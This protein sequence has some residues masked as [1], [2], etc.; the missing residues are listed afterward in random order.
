MNS[1]GSRDDN[2]EQRLSLA[3]WQLPQGVSRSLWEFAQAKHIPR[4]EGEHLAGSK[5]LEFDR[6]CVERWLTSP[7]R[8]AD[9]GCGTGRLAVP[10]AERGFEVVGVDLSRESLRVAEEQAAASGVSLQLVEG[11]LCDLSCLAAESFDAALLMFATLGMVSGADNRAEVLRQA[12]RLLK[13]GGMLVLHVHSVWSQMI[14]PAGRKWLVRD[15][16]RRAFGKKDAGDT[17]RDYRGI[18]GMFHHLFTRG[19]VM[20]LIRRGGFE[21]VEVVEMSNDFSGGVGGG[22]GSRWPWRVAGWI[23]LARAM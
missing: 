1:P 20:R 23:V 14:A 13:A 22:G 9:L 17:Y 3:D 21:S 11:N 5:L 2:A 15:L 18:P 19:E 16:I 4:E 6:Q 12:R 10:L 8:V 7:C